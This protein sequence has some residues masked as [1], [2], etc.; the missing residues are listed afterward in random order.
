MM[1]KYD[2]NLAEVPEFVYA[3]ELLLER[4]QALLAAVRHV[5][6][7]GFVHMDIKETNVSVGWDGSWWLGDFGSTVREGAAITS[8]TDDLHPELKD[9]HLKPPL[10]AQLRF[11]I[12]MLAALLVRQLDA[13]T[14]RAA[15][16]TKPCAI[17]ARAQRMTCDALRALLSGLLDEAEVD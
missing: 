2:H 16:A 15:Y 8:T 1:P 7:A 17:S 13:P 10:P 9:W 5:H 12:Y 4:A 6:G 3:E 14:H 11:D